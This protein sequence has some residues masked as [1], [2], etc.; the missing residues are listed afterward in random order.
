[1]AGD[2]GWFEAWFAAGYFPPVWFAQSDEEQQD[3]QL[4]LVAG[5]FLYGREPKKKRRPRLAF[6]DPRPIIEP[7]RRAVEEEEALLLCHAL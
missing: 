7:Q 3:N 1:M 6:Y 2:A 4:P 5:G